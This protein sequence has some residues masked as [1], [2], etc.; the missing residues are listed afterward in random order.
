MADNLGIGVSRNLEVKDRAWDLVVWRSGKPILD[1]EL[2]ITQQIIENKLDLLG[3]Q[4]ACGFLEKPL[5]TDEVANLPPGVISANGTVYG[6]MTFLMT[7]CKALIAGKVIDVLYGDVNGGIATDQQSSL[8]RIGVP[9]VDRQDLVFLECWEQLVIANPSTLGKPSVDKVYPYG[10]TQW[11]NTAYAPDDLQDPSLT[12]STTSRVQMQYRIRIVE[13]VDFANF[14]E[15]VNFPFIEAQGGKA[16][17]ISGYTFELSN[18]YR[19]LYVA[20]DETSQAQTDLGTV[21]GLVYALPIARIQRRN[22]GSFSAL[23]LNGSSKYM[24]QLISDRPDGLF[25]DEVNILDIEDL[26]H[27]VSLAGFDTN[28][29]LREAKGSFTDPMGLQILTPAQQ[30]LASQGVKVLQIDDISPTDEVG[31]NDIFRPN[32]IRR[33][34]SDVQTIQPT[35]S[36][37]TIN[38]KLPPGVLGAN[39]AIGNQ[40]KIRIGS[41]DPQG[42]NITNTTPSTAALISDVLTPVAGLWTGLGTDNAIFTLSSTSGGLTNQN[43]IIDYQITYPSA[44][45]ISYIAEEYL[46]VYDPTNAQEVFYTQEGQTYR[47]RAI[48]TRV[49]NGF[50][51]K[52]FD[53]SVF[54]S[55]G[56]SPTGGVAIQWFHLDG[57]NSNIFT[58]PNTLNNQGVINV[59]EVWD[60]SASPAPVRL[61]FTESLA[62][63]NS[64]VISLGSIYPVGKTLK[65][66]VALQGQGIKF[67]RITKSI[68]EYGETVLLT[69][70]LSSVNSVTFDMNGMGLIPQGRVQSL[71][72]SGRCFISNS[73]QNVTWTINRASSTIT[74][75]FGGIT[76]GVFRAYVTKTRTLG[77]TDRLFIY[78][79]R[80]PYQGSFTLEGRAKS[81]PV[82]PLNDNLVL[83]V[84]NYD[85]VT[86]MSCGTGGEI[87]DLMNNPT[88]VAGLLERIPFRYN[89]YASSGYT[90]SG[91]N[92]NGY[93]TAAFSSQALTIANY[94][95]SSDSI[96]QPY[97]NTCEDITNGNLRGLI[98]FVSIGEIQNQQ[99]MN[100]MFNLSGSTN[101]VN[102]AFVLCQVMRSRPEYKILPGEIVLLTISETQFNNNSSDINWKQNPLN[103][104]WDIFT[105][106]GRPLI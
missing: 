89:G 13:G 42:T 48:P 37:F 97:R 103:C 26:R 7:P 92:T 104:I 66:V 11:A 73:G 96:S 63:D 99:H 8:I 3:Q 81:Y 14:P 41:G 64:L 19:G 91:Y 52:F 43:L 36:R 79:L 70:T 30:T 84:L 10:N 55:S 90:T 50:P 77:I 54:D 95:T 87:L 47:E 2:N 68:M 5:V 53:I 12:A 72:Y 9:N 51:D 25:N 105:L 65:F 93:G 45:G 40:V 56:G 98:Q 75:T 4:Y 23:N 59:Y 32:A 83:K 61:D 1:S 33:I 27:H 69:K 57:A 24:S 100:G 80:R 58:I 94:G 35:T 106:P 88:P 16:T 17:P 20:G 18:Q 34:A 74:A 39:W 46:K 67:N 71:G 38:D 78:Y 28:D 86:Q 21:N 85:Q 101:H 60:M 102:T 62:I 82:A 44:H 29:L 22:I 6:P 31:M 49:I 76:S 15:G